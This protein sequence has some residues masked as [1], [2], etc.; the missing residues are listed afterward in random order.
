MTYSA[1]FPCEDESFVV[2]HFLITLVF[3]S[4]SCATQI[5]IDTLI[6]ASVPLQMGEEEIHPSRLLC[7]CFLS[8]HCFAAARIFCP[9]GCAHAVNACVMIEFFVW[10]GGYHAIV[11]KGTKEILD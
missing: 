6:D 7:H 9:I 11:G 8:A 5:L 4:I 3:Q 2:F 1:H 10:N